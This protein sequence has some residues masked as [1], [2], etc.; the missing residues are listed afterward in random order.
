VVFHGKETIF[1]RLKVRLLCSFS[2]KMNCFLSFKGSS[3]MISVWGLGLWSKGWSF[4]EFCMKRED[5]Y[6]VLGV[7]F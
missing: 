1:D 5:L 4:M 2:W 7:G 6:L 3:C